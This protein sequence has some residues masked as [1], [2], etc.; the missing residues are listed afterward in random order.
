MKEKKPFFKTV[1]GRILL[2]VGSL[3]IKNQKGIKGTNNIDIV[4]A[5]EEVL[6]NPP[7]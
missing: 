4:D 6:K 3:V 1:V 7:K 2:F 5:A